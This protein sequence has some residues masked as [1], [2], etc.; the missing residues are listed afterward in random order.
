VFGIPGSGRYRIRPAF[1]RDHVALMRRVA[2]LDEDVVLDSVGPDGYTFDELLRMM[3]SALQGRTVFVKL[4]A[5]LVLVA[6]RVVGALVHD[7]ILTD[8]EIGA[9]MDDLLISHGE[10]TCPTRFDT[11]LHS[12]ADELGRQFASELDRHFKPSPRRQQ[13]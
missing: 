9:L 3:R 13:G 6:L 1:V 4:P 12:H 11:W 2:T 5:P 8:H 7:V 10:P